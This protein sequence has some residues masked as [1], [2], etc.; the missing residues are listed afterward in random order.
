M[1]RRKYIDPSFPYKDVD[2]AL[3]G[4]LYALRKKHGD[5]KK[6]MAKL[7]KAHALMLSGRLADAKEIIPNG[8]VP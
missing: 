1:L 5:N 3:P 8:D 7:D 4:K 2:L 6:M